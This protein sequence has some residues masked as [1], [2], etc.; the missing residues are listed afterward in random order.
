M[1]IIF[2]E[3]ELEDFLCE[4]NN[5]EN[6]LGLKFIARQVKIEPAGIIDILA[7]SSNSNCW[8]IIE[9]KKEN[10]DLSALAQGMSYLKFYQETKKLIQN[11]K[12]SFQRKRNFA[13]LLVGQNLDYFLHK[14]VD[15][16]DCD[17]SDNALMYSLFA[18]DFENGISFSFFNT[19]QE[20]Y[21]EQIC[22]ISER[23]DVN[24][25]NALNQF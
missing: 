20:K 3:K 18:V 13:L 9:L 11:R 12:I 4:G 14:I 10:L 16:F 17:V 15:H 7:Y 8:V 25:F 19:F 6:Y 5:L 24:R 2:S 1:Q 23:N 22:E 21:S